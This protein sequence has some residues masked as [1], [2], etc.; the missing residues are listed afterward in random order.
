MNSI[1]LYF[2]TLS[3]FVSFSLLAQYESLNQNDFIKLT[4]LKEEISL[5]ENFD[6]DLVN[7]GVMHFTNIYR[8]SKNRNLLSY[9]INLEKSASLHSAEMKKYNFFDHINRRNKNLKDL[10]DRADEAAYEKYSE[11]SENLYYGYIDLR[12]IATYEELIKTIVKAFQDSK[13]HNENLLNKDLKEM[14]ASIV[15]KNNSEDGFLYYY[16]TQSFGTRF[17][18]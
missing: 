13:P 8:Q 11:L 10:D 18:Y 15:F 12:N 4:T 1:Q 2:I 3:L 9:N 14:G 7:V 5:D 16:V 6:Y 17:T